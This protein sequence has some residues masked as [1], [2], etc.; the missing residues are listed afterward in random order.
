LFALLSPPQTVF[1]EKSSDI[2]MKFLFSY[3][4]PFHRLGYGGGQQI[5]RGLSKALVALGHQV[6]VCCSGQDE[7]KIAISDDPVQY[8][9]TGHLN[10]YNFLPIYFHTLRKC[11]SLKPDVICSFTSEA[12]LIIPTCNIFGIPSVVYLAAPDLSCFKGHKWSLVRYQIGLYM[13]YLGTRQAK[14]V[15][16]ISDFTTSQAEVNWDISRKKISTI[17]VG[18]DDTFCNTNVENYKELNVNG[19]RLISFGRIA[20]NQKPLDV[21][22]EALA[23]STLSWDHWTIVGSGHEERML[24]EKLKKLH[25][26]EKVIFK[27]MQPSDQIADLMNRHDIVLL[28]TRYESFFITVYEAAAMAKIVITNDVAE[29]RHNFANSASVIIADNISKDAY[30]RAI[31]YAIQNFAVLQQSALGTYQRIRTEYGWAVIAQRFVQT[32]KDISRIG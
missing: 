7:M 4:Y 25:I 8:H 30:Q 13:Q 10:K 1:P 14:L 9:F 28:P 22:A 29:I 31:A 2:K 19:P 12:L 23:D 21:I 17:G 20:L 3:E 11:F 5:I 6:H 15:T 27:G 24:R 26:I 18:I 16:T 32:L